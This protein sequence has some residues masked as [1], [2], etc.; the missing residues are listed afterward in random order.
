MAGW[1]HNNRTSMTGSFKKLFSREMEDF[2]ER[3]NG[4]IEDDRHEIHDLSKDITQQAI[5]DGENSRKQRSESIAEKKKTKTI[6]QNCIK[7]PSL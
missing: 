1:L 7:T 5:H 4:K 6:T 3:R 2:N